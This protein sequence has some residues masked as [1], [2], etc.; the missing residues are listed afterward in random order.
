LLLVC[1]P[2][3][4][5]VAQGQLTLLL[6]ALLTGV[7]LAV[8][9]GRQ[10]L[11]GALL[12]LAASLTLTPVVLVLYFLARGRWRG[13]TAT[14][15]WLAFINATTAL[16]LGPGAY[17]DYFASVLQ[18]VRG[19]PGSGD[20]VSLPALW[21]KLFAAADGYSGVWP[22]PRGPA[23]AAVGAT[24]SSLFLVALAVR[25]TL[26]GES[27]SAD[28][29]SFGLLVLTMIL[30]NPFAREHSLVLLA[31]PL[32][33]FY[34]DLPSVGLPRLAYGLCLVVFWISPVYFALVVGPRPSIQSSTVTTPRQVL[35]TQS[36]HL[37]ALLGLFALGMRMRGRDPGMGPTTHL[38]PSARAGADAGGQGERLGFARRLWASVGLLGP[39]FTIT[40]VVLGGTFLEAAALALGQENLYGGPD[41]L[42]TFAPLLL[43]WCWVTLGWAVW[44]VVRPLIVMGSHWPGWCRRPA[45][46]L[47]VLVAILMALGYM[48]SWGL[49]VRSGQF[50]NLETAQFGLENAGTSWF[51][52]Y[53]VKAEGPV[54]WLL[55]GLAVVCGAALPVYLGWAVRRHGP[56]R[57]TAEPDRLL[58]WLFITA[59]VVPVLR[60]CGQDPV[61]TRGE[62]R[63]E[64]LTHR[65]N[66]VFTLTADLLH[67]LKPGEEITACLD[68]AVLQPLTPESWRP[69][70]R[71]GRELPSIVYV[72]VESL[73]HDVVH[74]VHQGR[75]VMPH[76]NDLAR[77]GLHLPRTY[78]Q[79]THSDYSDVTVVSSLYPLRTPEHHY[80]R[81]SDPWPKTR[82]YDLLKPAGYATALISSQNESWGSMDKFLESP[83]LD[84]FYDA[85]R[86]GAS[87]RVS[88]LDTGMASAVA[89]GALRAG[90]LDD[91]HTIDVA[92]AWITEQTAQGRPFMVSIDFQDSHFPYELPPDVP[93]PFQPGTIDFDASF[94]SY[95]KEKT[96]VVRNAYYNALH[97]S[98]A[99][100]GRLVEA[101][102]RLGKL[103]NTILVVYGENGEAF[104][105]SGTVTHAREPVEPG[106]HVACVVHAPALLAPRTD[107][108]PVELI[109][110]TP[111]VLG[112][113]GWP[114]HPNF[115]GTNVLAPSRPPL[116]D[117][118][119]F[120]HV[121]NTLARS[122][123]VWLAGRWKF[124][125]DRKTGREKLLDI[126]TDPEEVKDLLLEQPQLAERLRGTLGTWRQGQLAYYHFPAYY[127]KYYPPHPTLFTPRRE[128]R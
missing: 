102:R 99:E 105:E 70:A 120:C 80:Y 29:R 69:P 62:A 49:Y 76:L 82:I 57:A 111:T 125:H 127:T 38:D 28:G 77:R 16:V 75:E 52:L 45:R 24:V 27:R 83:H 61:G 46:V 87:T 67:R 23:L 17:Q 116:E 5:H 26:R 53:L 66:P 81:A 128:G 103:E 110:I 58:E 79:S 85:E 65:L 121:E 113:L 109:D 106:T 123:A 34:R 96:E 112:L 20:D 33:L 35:T 95:P 64:A 114:P 12:A 6:L 51:W 10:A 118:L 84:L 19:L 122:D 31:L 21:H 115:Q 56:A 104:H 107:A 48:T 71:P 91:G 59:L 117:R 108:Y 30:V 1:G 74:L 36:M 2:L 11:A 47:T 43:L 4:H 119:V 13:V 55:S 93:R 88:S 9:A 14:L 32:A 90:S 101:L 37:Y 86:S 92:I 3:R 40:V 18:A 73:R 22:L 89:A 124:C 68:P 100:L 98:D 44:L 7:W 54:L 72:A 15:V 42:L 8:Q 50:A 126:V 97:K 25:K 78:C 41:R 94:L 60:C 39:N 63:Y